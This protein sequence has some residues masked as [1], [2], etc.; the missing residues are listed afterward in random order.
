MNWSKIIE[1]SPY[2]KLWD[3]LGKREKWDLRSTKDISFWLGSQFGFQIRFHT[4]KLRKIFLLTSHYI[5][6]PTNWN[7]NHFFVKR[8]FYCPFSLMPWHPY[9]KRQ[10][11]HFEVTFNAPF[12]QLFY[13]I[14]LYFPH[15]QVA[16]ADDHITGFTGHPWGLS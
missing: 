4:C 13:F 12:V 11:I 15:L 9:R 16:Q 2:E 8:E 10:Y 6:W 1:M 3:H 14:Y 5:T 7:L